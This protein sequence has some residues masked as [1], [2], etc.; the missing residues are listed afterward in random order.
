MSERTVTIQRGIYTITATLRKDETRISVEQCDQIHVVTDN[1]CVYNLDAMPQIQVQAFDD[2][3][4]D[5]GIDFFDEVDAWISEQDE[6]PDT[7]YIEHVSG[8]VIDVDMGI[9]PS[10]FV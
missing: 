5:L 1:I 4:D 8:H 3:C 10:D 7:A 9:L 6:N 2:T